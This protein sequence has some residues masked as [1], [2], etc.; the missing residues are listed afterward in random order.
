MV[1]VA[2]PAS[3][4]RDLV[5]FLSLDRGSGIQDSF[6][7]DPESRIPDPKPILLRA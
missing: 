5:P 2:N 1:S 3:G 6:F 4:I 7:T